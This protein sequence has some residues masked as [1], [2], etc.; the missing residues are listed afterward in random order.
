MNPQAQEVQEFE[1][2]RVGDRVVVRPESRGVRDAVGDRVP[3]TVARLW[4]DGVAW[5]TLPNGEDLGCSVDIFIGRLQTTP[6]GAEIPVPPRA[7]FMADLER[8]TR[9]LRG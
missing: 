1:G 6:A 5:V 7:R 2:W 9:R 8:A 3:T 4:D